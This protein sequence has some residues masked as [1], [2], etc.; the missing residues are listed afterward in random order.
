MTGTATLSFID[1]PALRGREDKYKEVTLSI[2]KI[3]E[4]WRAS[5]FSYEWMH[6][7]GRIKSRDE[8]PEREQPKRD[9]AEKALAAGDALEKPVLG[10]GM[11]ENVEIGA[12][13]ALLLT[14][15]A[16]GH[17]TIKAHIPLSHEDEFT[18]FL[19]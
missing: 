11:L 12:G 8:L 2:P 16:H 18:A 1:N 5:L 14:M 7:D 4:S 15:A 6:P 13:R 10:I 19:A 17:K 9:A 3:I